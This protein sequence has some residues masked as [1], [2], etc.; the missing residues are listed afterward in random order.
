MTFPSIHKLRVHERK[1]EVEQKPFK[2]PVEGCDREFSVVQALTSH[3][4]THSGERA[5]ACEM[6]GCGKRFT[7]ASKLKLHL[8]SHTGERPFSCDV[9]VRLLLCYLRPSSDA[10]LFMSRT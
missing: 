2:C 8:R 9:Q 3:A 1:H 4:R 10:D 6:E 7:K 5:H